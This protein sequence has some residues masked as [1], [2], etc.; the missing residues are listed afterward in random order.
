MNIYGINMINVCI[1]GNSFM[2]GVVGLGIYD[3]LGFFYN[4]CYYGV[5]CCWMRWG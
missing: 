3:M 4:E 1:L 5:G 2:F